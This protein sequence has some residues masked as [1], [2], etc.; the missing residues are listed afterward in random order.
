MKILE[1]L[2]TAW[3]RPQSDPGTLVARQAR[4]WEVLADQA[5]RCAALALAAEALTARAG[6]DTINLRALITGIRDTIHAA[7]SH[8]DAARRWQSVLSARRHVL[9]E[10]WKLQ[11]KLSA[12]ESNALYQELARDL[13]LLERTLQ[14]KLL[15]MD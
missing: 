13:A 12:A 11:D 5:K 3:L 10:G 6:L 15:E 9:R 4:E 14:G 1:R 2:R 7:E 8:R